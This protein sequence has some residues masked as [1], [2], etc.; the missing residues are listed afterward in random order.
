MRPLCSHGCNRA[1]MWSQV[2]RIY[3][4]DVKPGQHLCAETSELTCVDP[5]TRCMAEPV[6]RTRS[7]FY[8]DVGI[9]PERARIETVSAIAQHTTCRCFVDNVRD[10]LP[11]PPARV[12]RRIVI[13][14]RQFIAAPARASAASS[15]RPALSTVHRAVPVI[16]DPSP[17]VPRPCK[18]LTRLRDVRV[19]MSCSHRRCATS[20]RRSRHSTHS[21]SAGPGDVVRCGWNATSR[22]PAWRVSRVADLALTDPTR[23]SIE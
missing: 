2:A 1:T 3:G 23:P 14:R 8:A 18:F 21:V 19:L 16:A 17:G 20:A 22:T 9:R 13:H 4:R 5:M 7:A 10:A 12:G 15:G 11:L 6:R